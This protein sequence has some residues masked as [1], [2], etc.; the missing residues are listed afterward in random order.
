[1]MIGNVITLSTGIDSP[2][3]TWTGELTFPI[4]PKKDPFERRLSNAKHQLS[5]H[6]N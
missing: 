5:F 3:K 2:E 1:M 6:I 4:N